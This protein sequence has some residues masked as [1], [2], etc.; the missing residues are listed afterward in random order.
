MRM[1]NKNQ[2]D[3]L[4]F[5][6]QTARTSP[7]HKKIRHFIVAKLVKNEN[8]KRKNIELENHKNIWKINPKIM[9]KDRTRNLIQSTNR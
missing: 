2:R 3:T 4:V 6:L 5:N 9:I 8:T 1:E 7:C